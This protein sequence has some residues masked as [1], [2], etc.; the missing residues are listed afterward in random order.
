VY[1]DHDK[2]V[3]VLVPIREYIRARSPPPPS[4]CR[5]LRSHFHRLIML[6]NDYQ[7]LSTAGIAQRIAANVGNFHAVLAH[8]LDSGEPDFTETV[9]SILTFDSFYRI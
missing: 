8:G 4:L 6:W 5:P 1:L 7:H 3:R 2:R 9:Y